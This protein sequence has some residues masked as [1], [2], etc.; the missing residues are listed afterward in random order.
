MPDTGST[1]GSLAGGAIGSALLP[2]V[3]TMVGSK[4]G[5]MAGGK[6][7]GAGSSGSPSPPGAMGAGLGL[8]TGLFQQIQAN[9]LKKKAN[10]ALPPTIDPR[11]A[12]FLAELNQKRKAI[13]TGADFA[14]GMNAINQTNATTNNAIVNASGGDAGGTLQGLLQSEGVA[15]QGKNNVLAQGQ[16]QQ[17]QYNSM[18]N[19]LNNKI[20]GRAL[21]LQMYRSQQA[22]A[23]WAQKQQHA[24]QNLQAGMAGA[25]SLM[26]MGGKGGAGTPSPAGGIIPDNMASIPPPS[27]PTGS[28]TVPDL[29]IL[30]NFTSK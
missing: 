5:G 28:S 16:Q 4:L 3:G 2:G 21:Q 19:D 25:S 23:E 22:R 7:G 18:F 27:L 13:D 10:S 26:S 14:S 20:A 1:I 17:M 12:S 6:I 11:Q 29:S 9:A 24:S 8:A 30:N 15:N